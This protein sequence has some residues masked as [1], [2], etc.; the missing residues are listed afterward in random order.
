MVEKLFKLL[1]SIVFLAGLWIAREAASNGR[2]VYSPGIADP[3]HAAA[4]P[5]P[6]LLDTRSGTIYFVWPGNSPTGEKDVSSAEF[7]PKTGEWILHRD[8]WQR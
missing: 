5:T 7:R 1:I 6:V 8:R 2:Y 3:V 4:L